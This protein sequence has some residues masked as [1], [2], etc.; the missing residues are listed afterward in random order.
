MAN[1]TPPRWPTGPRTVFFDD[2][3][4]RTTLSKA[5]TAGRIQRLAPK[6]YSADITSAP[7]TIVIANWSQICGRLVP[8]AVIV[9][10]S[11]ATTG[12]LAEATLTIAANTTRK[13]ISMPGLEIRIRQ[14][15]PID[16]DSPWTDGLS[17]S[18]PAR[19][20]VDNLDVSRGRAGRVART[21]SLAEV[22]DWLARKAIAWGPER[23]DRLRV[24]AR[25]LASTTDRAQHLATIDALF[26][27]L[28]GLEP[29][30]PQAGQLFRAVTEGHA[31][32]ERRLEMFAR[33]G[34]ALSVLSPPAVPDWLEGADPPGELPFYESYF[35]NYIEGTLFTVDEARAIVESQ[36]PPVDRPADGH[37]ILGTHRCVVDPIGRAATSSDPDELIGHLVARHREIMGGRPDKR[38]GEWKTTNNQVGT[39]RFVEP[40]LVEGTLRKGLDAIEQ[41][42]QG[43]ARALYIMTVV[44]EVHPF[45]DGNGRVARVMMNAE[46]SAIGAAR[47]VIPSVYRNEYLAGLRRASTTTGDLTAYIKIMTYA[48]RWTAAMPWADPAA[49]EGQLAATNALLDSTD[50]QTSGL[51][52]ELP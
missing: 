52:L 44:S 11:A 15:H 9:D 19:T 27:Q 22:E 24:D 28:T 29:P 46:L 36:T 47:I 17:M 21:L 2:V 30:R 5:V 26:E 16:S 20:L 51:R 8:G 34:E 42:P 6:I 4:S 38:P 41:L 40:D 7:E 25:N 12:V 31:W 1:T 3:A 43:F 49:T 14:G 33:A 32:D 50:A 18:S 23:T 37:D 35:S 13:K 39:Y 48:W 10:R 45:V